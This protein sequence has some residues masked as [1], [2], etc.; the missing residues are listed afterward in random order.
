MIK[1]AIRAFG[2]SSPARRM[3][4]WYAHAFPRH[5]CKRHGVRYALD[6]SELID[7]QIYLGGWEPATVSFLKRTVCAGD[8]VIE[9]GANVGAHTLIL[10]DQVGEGGHVIAFEPTKFATAKLRAN[11][12]LNPALMSRVTLRSELVTNHA[13]ALPST[14]IVSS[15]PVVGQVAYKPEQVT[16]DAVALDDLNVTRLDLLKIDVDGYDFKVLE[17]ASAL[18]ETLRPTVLIELCEHSLKRQGDSVRDIFAF[19]EARGYTAHDEHGTRLFCDEVLAH[20]G[21]WG[22]IN[23]VFMAAGPGARER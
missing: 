12:A 6:L 13:G 11:L 18:L 20:I 8:V 15:F 9:V 16:A 3:F 23:A 1:K 17:G 7:R 4:E 10:A 22:G 14:A 5:T 21:N 2:L 19:M